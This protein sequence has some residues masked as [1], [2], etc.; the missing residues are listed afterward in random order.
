MNR[1]RQQEV[2]YETVQGSRQHNPNVVGWV[3]MKVV[4]WP[5]VIVRVVIIAAVFGLW[6]INGPRVGWLVWSSIPRVESA[7]DKNRTP[8]KRRTLQEVLDDIDDV[9]ARIRGQMQ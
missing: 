9:R 1:G 2:R 8:L 7:P 3:I 4:F 5:I 6:V